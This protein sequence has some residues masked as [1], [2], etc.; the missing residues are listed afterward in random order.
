MAGDSV[1]DFGIVRS[2]DGRDQPIGRVPGLNEIIRLLKLQAGDPATVDKAIAYE[3]VDVTD[4]AIAVIPR[5]RA[6]TEVWSILYIQFST[7]S[8][9]G[10]YLI[11][12]SDPTAAGRGVPILA[13]GAQ[14]I[15]RGVD[16][17]NNFKMIAETGQTME[18]N[19]LL[20]KAPAWREIAR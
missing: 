3:Q 4:A 14:L 6:N 12:G 20:F 11:D 18:A 15:I 7:P 19:C 16:N 13:G 9:T 8:G 17:I 1:D 5:L 2:L 10:R